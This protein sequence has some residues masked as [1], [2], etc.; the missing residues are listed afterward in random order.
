[1]I[2]RISTRWGFA[3]EL[4]KASERHEKGDAERE[5]AYFC[6]E[7]LE[8]VVAETQTHDLKMSSS[9]MSRMSARAIMAI[10]PRNMGSPEASPATLHPF[11]SK[12][13]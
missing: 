12:S 9:Q 1:V 7:D 8:V 5:D 3:S 11:L 6:R 10:P 4:G 2:H 13:E